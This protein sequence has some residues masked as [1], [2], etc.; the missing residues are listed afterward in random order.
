MAMMMAVATQSN[1]QG[2]AQNAWNAE[3]EQVQNGKKCF[4]SYHLLNGGASLVQVAAGYFGKNND[5]TIVVRFPSDIALQSSLPVS[6]DNKTI[7][8][9]IPLHCNSAGC[10]ASVLL[11]PQN[12]ALLYK[13][14]TLALS[15]SMFGDPRV[16]T[17]TIPL[18]GFRAI[19][20]P[21]KK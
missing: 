4:A 14:Q 8:N 17:G 10:F 1:A 5:P 13:S 15:F 6:V 16:I 9:L 7:F 20:E 19:F 18:A 2:S 12:L 3:C 21:L 11:S